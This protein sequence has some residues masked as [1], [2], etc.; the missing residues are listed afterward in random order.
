M[1]TM[2]SVAIIIVNW[3]GLVYTDECL[4][5]LRE[6]SYPNHKIILVDNGSADGSVSFFRRKYPKVGIIEH[7]ENLGF[8]GGYNAGMGKALEQE[9]DYVLL[10]NNDTIV[11]E[12]DF[13]SK[14]IEC[15]EDDEKIGMACPT[16]YYDNPSDRAWYAGGWVSLWKGWGHHHQVPEDNAPQATGYTTGCCLLAKAETIEDIGLLNVAYFLCVED[17]EWSVRAKKKGWKTVYVPAPSIIHKDSLSSRSKGKGMYSPTRVYHE[18][19]NGIWFIREYANTFQKVVVWP[20]RFGSRYLY[21]S[22]AYILLGR[23]KKLKALYRGMIDG[24]FTASE[25]FKRM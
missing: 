18:F 7:T 12:A 2:P 20:V 24:L 25:R 10:L 16:I 19:R 21:K 4:E 15:C 11:K 13:L 9:F 6:L 8:T 14:M 5:S 1:K 23:G 17:V 22:A 3:N